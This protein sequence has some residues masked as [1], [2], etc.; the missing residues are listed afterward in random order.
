MSPVRI[1]RRPI[2]R[3]TRA[4]GKRRGGIARFFDAVGEC[5]QGHHFRVKPR[6]NGNAMRIFGYFGF[7]I[8]WLLAP[9]PIAMAETAP[10]VAPDTTLSSPQPTPDEQDLLNLL[11]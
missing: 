6:G 9:A 4:A 1:S 2:L 10:V 11:D 5:S 3:Q 8:V 7:V